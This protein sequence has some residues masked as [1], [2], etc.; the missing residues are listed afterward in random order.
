MLQFSAH[1]GRRF[2]G[3]PFEAR[4]AAAKAAGFGAVEYPSPYA[5]GIDYFDECARKQG[6]AVAQI[7]APAGDAGKGDKGFACFS[8]RVDD[9]RASIRKGLAAANL[10]DCPSLLVR[11]GILREDDT[12]GDLRSDY[13]DNMR[14]AAEQCALAEVKLLI[15]PASEKVV[16]G[17]FL[18]DMALAI[19]VLNEL[20][21]DAVGLLFNVYQAHLM[22]T[23]PVKF[24]KDHYDLIRH[25]HVADHPG[26]NQ[27][28]TGSIDFKSIF[29]VLES[30][31]F[32]GWIGCDYSARPEA[33]DTLEWYRSIL[34]T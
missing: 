24:V 11:A 23:D 19:S 27:P 12:R 33:D 30:R 6:L 13:I 1:L 9:F 31:S 16:P 14:W 8:F 29:S 18:N 3:L 2:S 4:F 25:F 7:T 21:S 10:L 22:G 17:Y 32:A 15:E 20:N 26:R 34:Q 28:G 5:V